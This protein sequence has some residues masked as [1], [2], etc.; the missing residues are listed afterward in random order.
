MRRA[1]LLISMAAATTISFGGCRS[2]S[3]CHDYDP[4][5]AS[6]DC[7]ACGCHRAGS[8]SAGSVNHGYAGGE[9]AEGQ[10]DLAPP[11]EDSAIE[12]PAEAPQ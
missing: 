7:N 9:Y 5:V 6:G 3:S 1:I 10:Y 12:A 11:I 8:A 2:C 4:P